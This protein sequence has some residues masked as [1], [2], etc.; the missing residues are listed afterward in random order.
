MN[1]KELWI[2]RGDKALKN[3]FRLQLSGAMKRHFQIKHVSSRFAFSA[4]AQ[5][6]G[7]HP[8]LLNERSAF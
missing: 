1:L 6:F 4:N 7:H 8:I 5:F 3:R 2:S